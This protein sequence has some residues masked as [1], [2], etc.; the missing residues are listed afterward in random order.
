MLQ[1]IAC[2]CTCSAGDGG[3]AGCAEERAARGCYDYAA[4]EA[5]CEVDPT[6]LKPMPHTVT[7]SIT[8]GDSPHYIRLQADPTKLNALCKVPI[9]TTQVAHTYIH[10]Y[11]L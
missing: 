4:I 6:K 10:T 8:Y 3:K 9:D 2:D 5:A 11:I 1:L 7:A